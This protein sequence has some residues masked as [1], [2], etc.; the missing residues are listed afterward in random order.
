MIFF[1]N[2]R[3][4]TALFAQTSTKI[5]PSTSAFRRNAPVF[6]QPNVRLIP[7]LRVVTARRSKSKK[8][9]TRRTAAS[10]SETEEEQDND[11]WDKAVT[12]KHSKL[13]HVN[14]SSLRVDALLRSGLGIARNKV[15][16]LFYENKVRVN[17]H[18]LQ[19]KSEVAQEGDEI[20]IVKEV[21]PNNPD[22]LTVARVEVLSVKPREEGY[23]VKVRRCKSLV[24]ENYL[25]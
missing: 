17:G 19:K 11:A 6:N 24:V 20:D 2:N 22:L 16:T 18:A 3:L 12:D 9:R 15:E 10:E 8:E 1:R 25:K 13:M 21:N 5:L 7:Q 23:K 14:V 4:I